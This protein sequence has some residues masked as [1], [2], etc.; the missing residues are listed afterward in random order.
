MS[1]L[2]TRGLGISAGEEVVLNMPLSIDISV[3]DYQV[4][5]VISDPALSI[6][7]DDQ[8]VSVDIGG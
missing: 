3:Q 7:V 6:E 5:I 1:L 8:T 4:D 2:I